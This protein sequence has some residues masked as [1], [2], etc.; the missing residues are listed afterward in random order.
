MLV[1]KLAVKCNIAT[2]RTKDNTSKDRF[3]FE[4]AKALQFL[5]KALFQFIG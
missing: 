1:M 5:T 2:I 3:F 4:E